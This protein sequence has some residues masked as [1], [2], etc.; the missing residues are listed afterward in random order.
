MNWT[1]TSGPCRVLRYPFKGNGYQ[2]ELDEVARCLRLGLV[3]SPVMPLRESVAVMETLDALR[4]Q[5]G[6]MYPNE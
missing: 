6:L 1:E 5:W 3:E 2:F 4:R